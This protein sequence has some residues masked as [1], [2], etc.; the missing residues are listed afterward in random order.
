MKI[1][2]YG[3]GRFGSFWASLLGKTFQVVGY[4]RSDCLVPEGVVRGDLEDLI[5][6]D[7]IFLCVAISAM[8]SVVQ[9]LA[10]RLR[11]GTLLLDTCSVKVYPAEIMEQYVPKEV[12]LIATH[13]MFGPD[14][15]KLGPQGLPLILSPLRA[16][17][18]LVDFWEQTFLS[19]GVR[20]Y[21]MSPEEHDRE[22]A[23]T[24]GITHFVGRILDK[25]QLQKSV[26][27]TR[28]YEKLLE[29]IEQTCNDPEQLFV[30]LQRRN[31]YTREMRVGLQAAIQDVMGSLEVDS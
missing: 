24:Q 28:G 9:D 18:A 7:A 19:W 3:L 25:M 4:N 11:P 5:E 16:E 31:G 6:C 2:V 10:P 26:I 14:S 17:S 27:G 22:A 12:S 15:A 21:R 13:P 1:G 20:V 30:D 29:I 23:Y 8:D